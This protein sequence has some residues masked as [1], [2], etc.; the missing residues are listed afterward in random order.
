MLGHGNKT[1]YLIPIPIETLDIDHFPTLCTLH[2]HTSMLL[3]SAQAFLMHPVPVT[4][5]K[6]LFLRQ[7]LWPLTTGKWFLLSMRSYIFL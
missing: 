1:L 2:E 3:Q 4:N 5:V 6:N 7:P